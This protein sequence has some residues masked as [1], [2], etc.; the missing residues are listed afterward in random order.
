MRRWL[1]T[2]PGMLV[3]QWIEEIPYLET[4]RYTKRVLASWGTYAWL[5][6]GEL[7]PLSQRVPRL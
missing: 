2:R 6:T 5:E 3:D 7:P 4:R 1:E